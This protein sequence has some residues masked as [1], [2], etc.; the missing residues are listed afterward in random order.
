MS[1]WLIDVTAEDIKTAER[2]L[3]Y[4]RGL[5]RNASDH[6]PVTQAANR[7]FD[8]SDAW[9]GPGFVRVNDTH[10]LLPT[11]ARLFVR[12]FDKGRSV[13]PLRFYLITPCLL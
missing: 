10:Y 9:T 5:W 3:G 7:A 8:V 4:F 6:C 1:E 11:E 2:K 13:Q 12:D